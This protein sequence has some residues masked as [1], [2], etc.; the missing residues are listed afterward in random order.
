[1]SQP[2]AV[3]AFVPLIVAAVLFVQTRPPP[4][5]PHVCHADSST[6][7]GLLR[8]ATVIVI[9]DPAI[10]LQTA[11]DALNE[12]IAVEVSGPITHQ[13]LPPE[14]SGGMTAP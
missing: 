14:M 1:M 4:P 3:P 9:A 10:V 7:A 6:C 2:R 11:P 5:P 13:G 12:W 8:N